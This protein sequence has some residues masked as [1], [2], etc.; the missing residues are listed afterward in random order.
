MRAHTHSDTN[1]YTNLNLNSNQVLN[2]DVS[3]TEQRQN[4]LT[5]LRFHPVK[6][7]IV[8]IASIHDSLMTLSRLMDIH[9]SS[10]HCK[11]VSSLTCTHIGA[12]VQ[13]MKHRKLEHLVNGGRQFNGWLLLIDAAN[14]E[15]G[16]VVNCL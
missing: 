11:D 2:T 15:L 1:F 14:S 10:S 12:T 16:V 13:E 9:M 6:S 8:C 7:D 3:K 5:F 4:V